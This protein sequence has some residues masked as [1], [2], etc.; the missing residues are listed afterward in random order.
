VQGLDETAVVR[1]DRER[2]KQ[3]VWNLLS[4]AVKFTRDGGTIRVRVLHDQHNAI[5]EV[6][7]DGEGIDGELLHHLFD[8]FTQGAGS[9]R[10]G[11]LGLGLSIVRHIVELHR[12]A[13]TAYSAGPN[14]GSTFTVTL[15]LLREAGQRQPVREA[16][17]APSAAD[18]A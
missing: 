17:S 10:K 7:D 11:G 13:V 2:L 8:R 16:L 14:R 3:V 5:V 12:G 6:A 4:N 1:G 9:V 15:P 18:H